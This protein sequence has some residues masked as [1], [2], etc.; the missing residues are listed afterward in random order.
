MFLKPADTLKLSVL[1][2]RYGGEPQLV[3][4][5]LSTTM[6][7]ASSPPTFCMASETTADLANASLYKRTLPPHRLEGIASQHDCWASPPPAH[8]NAPPD[9]IRRVDASDS[10]PPEHAQRVDTSDSHPPDLAQ[11]VD[12][13]D[14]SLTPA[15]QPEDRPPLHTLRGPSAHVDVFDTSDSHPP[16]LAQRVDPNDSSLTP[17]PQPEDRHPLHTLRGPLAHVDVFVDDFIG[18]AQGSRRWCRNVRRC[19][20]HAVDR[21]FAERTPQTLQRKEAV[22]ERKLAKGNGGWN[23]RKEV[24]G[25]ILDTERGTLELTDRRKRRIQEIFDSLR[26]HKRVGLKTWQCVLGELRFMGP[27]IPGSAGLFGALQLGLTH[28][29]RHRV[30]VTPDLR[31]HLSDFEALARDVSQRPTRLAE[32]VPDYPSAIGSVDAAKTGMGGVIFIP[33]HPPTLWRA[34]F[35]RDIQERIITTENMTG[36]LTNSDLEQAGVLAQ[37]DV[38]VSL[39]DM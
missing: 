31:N 15:L 1:M 39:Y 17:V 8:E 33:G 6:G 16:D 20:L 28:S 2:P 29:D 4:V 35:P 7:W 19:I 24:L 21:V 25:W 3:A 9:S 27:A 10:P 12:T 13:N 32:I 36:D 18:L 5:P 37:A 26:D 38:T 22:S 34:T 23:R 30:C 14:S 11:R